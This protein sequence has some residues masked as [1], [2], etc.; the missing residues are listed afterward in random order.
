MADATFGLCLC[1]NIVVDYAEWR[2]LTVARKNTCL[3]S[4]IHNNEP[5]F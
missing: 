2:I 4:L 5:Q 3:N 1:D